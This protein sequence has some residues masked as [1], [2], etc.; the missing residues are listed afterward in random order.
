VTDVKDLELDNDRPWYQRTYRWSQVNLTESDPQD[1]DVEEWIDYWQKTQTQG[2]IINAGGLVAYYPS[3]APLQYHARFLERRDLFGEFVTAARSAGLTVVARMDTN[4]TLPH[5]YQ[6][7]PDWFVTDSNGVSCGSQKNYIPCIN[8]SF[9]TEYVPELI[10]EIVEKYH[11]DGFTDNNWVSSTRMA[12]GMICHCE[13]CQKTFMADTGLPLPKI[14]DWNDLTYKKWIRWNY[15]IRT[16]NWDFMQSLTRRLGG[17]NCLWTGMLHG[18]PSEA[19]YYY[20][21]L[22]AI[23]ERSPFLLIDHQ[24]R[25]NR[26]GLS[27]NGLVGN[28]MHDLAGWDKIIACCTGT[29]VSDTGRFRLSSNPPDETRMWSL[30]GISGGL[31]P[32][33]H[34]LGAKQ[35]DRRQRKIAEP[36]MRWHQANELYLTDRVPAA[37]VG[38][39]W[40]GDNIEFFG[41][42]KVNDRFALPWQGFKRALIRRRITF[43]PIHADHIRQAADSIQVLILPELA[44]MSDDQCQ[45]VRE[46]VQTGGSVILTGLTATLDSWG[47]RR[48]D[49]PFQSITGIS[50]IEPPADMDEER[51]DAF[52]SMKSHSYLRIDAKSHPIFTGFA[53]TDILA[54]GGRLCKPERDET[55]QVLSTFIPPFP[56]YP[57]EFSWMRE[58]KTDV[59]VILAGQTPAGGRLVYLAGDLDRCYGRGN[60]PDHG[61]LLANCVQWALAGQNLLKVEGPGTLDCRLYRQADRVILHLVNLSGQMQ[62]SGFVEEY[63]PVGPLQVSIK[64]NNPAIQQAYL[65]VR[66]QTANVRFADGW[67]HF[68]VPQVIDHEMVILE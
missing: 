37:S 18:D 54:F 12:G 39:V 2:V 53:E 44:A 10:R 52:A 59:P 65:T 26:D 49:Y 35:Y 66:Q 24:G 38:L 56:Y 28:L 48:Q 11:P 31:S 43:M 22:K 42:D 51:I 55:M 21:D 7:H 58:P 27:A 6:A 45:A 3:S 61:D 41:R 36:V 20:H 63:L 40:S 67:L 23:G 4:K 16:R 5:I 25:H 19:K 30:E 15:K 33:I 13:H 64:S 68:K 34:H 17:P 47:S 14:Q 32:W 57:P 1:C 29:Y 50:K 46:F 9:H 60:L 8:G 62:K